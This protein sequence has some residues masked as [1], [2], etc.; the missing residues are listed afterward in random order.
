MSIG[1]MMQSCNK[2]PLIFKQDYFTMKLA[3]PQELP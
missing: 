3:Q 2:H 1:D